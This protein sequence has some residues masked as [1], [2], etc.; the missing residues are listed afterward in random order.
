MKI[1]ALETIQL[2]EFPNLMWLRVHT[3]QGL[4]GLGETFFAPGTVA[5]YIHEV[6]AHKLLG[7]DPRRIDRISRMLAVDYY[8]GIGATG[9]ETRAASAVDIALWDILGQ[10]TNQPI[11]QLLG[12]LSRDR[13]RIYNTC[14]GYQYVRK[15]TGQ[16]AENFGLNKKSDGPYEDLDAFL[17]RADELAESLLSEGITA[18][19]IWPFDWAAEANGGLHI[20]PSEMDTALEPFRKI[21]KRVGNK[22]DIMVELHSLWNLTTAKRIFVALEEFD[23]YW[24][25]D[26]VKMSNLDAVEQLARFT[27]VPICA[28][29]TLASRY[30]YR[31][32]MARNAAGIIMPDLG[33]VGGISEAKKIAT[34]AEAH[35]LPVAPHDCTGPIV[36]VSSVHLSLNAPNALIQET[37]RAYTS[38]WYNELVTD[39]PRI[40]KGYAYPMTGPGLG[41]KLLPGLDKRKDATVRWS[42][43]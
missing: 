6:A 24:Y 4:V 40:E 43:A 30:A 35:H 27:R 9:V 31:D 5:N 39:L 11:H 37:V 34:M 10:M 8:V 17:N 38:G 25:E 18:M 1:T 21:R 22:I 33:W 29:E 13:I 16:L 3:D 7:A 23:P 41:T 12:G 42:K 15:A 20:S 32:L 26:P 14:A 2:G 28:S 19:K 36:L